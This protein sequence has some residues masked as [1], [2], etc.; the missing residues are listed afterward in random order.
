MISMLLVV[1]GVAQGSQDDAGSGMDAPDTAETAVPVQFNTT[2]SGTVGFLYS[3][4][5]GDE[6]LDD[7]YGFNV[8]TGFVH[9]SVEVT[10]GSDFYW[11]DVIVEQRSEEADIFNLF[12]Q[13]PRGE[14]SVPVLFNDTAFLHF[15]TFSEQIHYNFSISWNPG[16]YSQDD[17]GGGTDADGSNLITVDLENIYNGTM[18]LGHVKEIGDLDVNDAYKVILPAEGYLLV[19]FS[20]SGMNAYPSVNIEDSSFGMIYYDSGESGLATFRAPIGTAGEYILDIYDYVGINV[21]YQFF[22]SF[23]QKHCPRRMMLEVVVMLILKG[24]P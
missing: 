18:G 7:Y 13:N 6:D 16:N 24:I 9:V 11:M 8:T 12:E 23:S 17:A 19:N 21:S 20:Y 5:S 4:V 15:R 3:D 10:G 22:L 2:Y 14:F 1:Q